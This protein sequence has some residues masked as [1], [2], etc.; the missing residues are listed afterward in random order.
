M[1]ISSCFFLVNLTT[2]SKRRVK[3]KIALG[4][5]FR[6]SVVRCIAD[7]S[8]DL[9]YIGESLCDLRKSVNLS[10]F[11]LM[12]TTS[13][14]PALFAG[15]QGPHRRDMNACLPADDFCS[16]LMNHVIPLNGS[17]AA[18]LKNN[19]N[20][21]TDVPSS[22]WNWAVC[23]YANLN[24]YSNVIAS[25]ATFLYILLYNCTYSLFVVLPLPPNNLKFQS[26][27]TQYLCNK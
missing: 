22:N 10:Q 16:L 17:T 27:C 4:S 21:I 3:S 13:R 19:N 23:F 5:V 18:S 7:G 25:S 11:S 8:G 9:E 14:H 24:Q 1:P 2:Y 20:K 6:E 26:R 12:K 15:L